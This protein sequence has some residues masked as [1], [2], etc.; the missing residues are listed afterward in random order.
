MLTFTCKA[1]GAAKV[2]MD[3]G[4]AVLSRVKGAK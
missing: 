4:N 2:R 3:Q 1:T